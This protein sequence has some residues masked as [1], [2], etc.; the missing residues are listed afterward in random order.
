MM[1]GLFPRILTALFLAV[2]AGSTYAGAAEDDPHLWNTGEIAVLRSLWIGSLPPIPKD[3]SNTY[4]ENPRAAALGKKFFFDS[5]FSG[6]MKVSCATCHRPDMNF[7]DNLPLA[8]GMGTTM[9][10]SMPLAGVA[11]NTWFFWDGRKDSLW[12][13]ALDPIESHVEHG[14]TR[15]ACVQ[16]IA[17]YYRT[18]YE[19]IFGPLPRL[20][21]EAHP[22]IASPA[23][24]DLLAL[25]A[26]L[27]IEPDQRVA[28][29]RVYANMGKAIAAFVRTIMPGPARFDRYTEAL[30]KGDRETMQQT[31]SPVE[32]KGLKLFIGRAGC[33]NCHTGPLFSNSDF[34]NLGLPR[35]TRPTTDSG[36]ADGIKKVL[37]DEFNCLGIYS[38]ADPA[39]CLELRFIDTETAKYAGAFKTP[40]LRNVAERAP[41]M[42]AG[43]FS[44]LREIMLFYHLSKNPELNHGGLNGEELRQVEAFLRTLTGPL[45]YFG[46]R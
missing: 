46:D 42:N 18:E 39:D 43:Q 41:Y 31:L 36:R 30:L 23:T 22:A 38:D 6:N 13:Q 17:E 5:R 11:Y 35:S 19:E 29:N 24:G 7:T 25:K 40:S 15:T 27:S 45:T 37:A 16:L 32:A 20:S 9:R 33:T 10:R 12:S 34:H 4:A 14:V 44:S 8:H 1:R 2:L 28:I 3:P 26:W 21:K